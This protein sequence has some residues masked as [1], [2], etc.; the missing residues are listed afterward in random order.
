MEIVYYNFYGLL[1]FFQIDLEDDGL[2]DH[3][4]QSFYI[5]ST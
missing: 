2:K 1:D 4:Q 5:T 3:D